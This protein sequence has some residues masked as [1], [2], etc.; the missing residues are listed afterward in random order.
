[1]RVF[2]DTNERTG[3]VEAWVEKEVQSIMKNRKQVV[4]ARSWVR[5]P[6]ADPKPHLVSSEL[7]GLEALFGP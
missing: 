7:G 1:M 3:K 2:Y 6:T 4:T 5:C